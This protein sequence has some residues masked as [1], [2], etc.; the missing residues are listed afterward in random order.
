[1]SDNKQAPRVLVIDDEMLQRKIVSRQLTQL[2]FVSD[3]AETAA[4]ALELLQIKDFDVV[5]LDIQM[6][7]ISGLEILPLIKKLED[8]P[9][10]IMLTLDKSLESGVAAMR[11]GACDYLTKPATL[12]GLEITVGKA[13]EKRRLIRKNKTLSDF[14][15]SR[16]AGA[17]NFLPPIQQ[18]PSMRSLVEQADAV[19]NLNSTVLIT[20]ESGTGKDVLARYIHRQSRRAK[21]AMVSVNCGAMPET[22]FDSEF[23]GYERGAFTG[24]AQTKRGLIEVADGSTLFLD[25]IG[26]MPSAL[27]VKLLRFLENGEFRRIGSTRDL[28]SDARLIAAT[29]RDLTESIRENRFRSDL[30]Y[31]LNVIHLHLPPLRERC[32][33]VSALIRYFLDFY[34]LQF[35]KPNLRF[36]ESARQKL[37]EY[38]FPGNVRELKNII[39]RASVLAADDL[40]EI[41]HLHFQKPS[42]IIKT[43]KSFAFDNSLL[44][45]QTFDSGNFTDKSI[46]E[47]GELERRYILSIL[48]YTKGNRERAAAL[49]GISERTLYRRLRDYE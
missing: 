42:E 26:E 28:F 44:P 22:L 37:E 1:M 27:Q 7:D 34:R 14:V 29:N 16:T 8:A 39:E 9:E 40:I 49:L 23:F 32:E 46:I 43:S 48:S 38:D 24:A 33:D 21:A 2:G 15:V 19:A 20:G 3:V 31:R 35:R 13:F 30:F 12:S 18:S 25:E 17:D 11:A 6:S 41:E 4:K 36:A 47:L 45:D 5:L 10:V